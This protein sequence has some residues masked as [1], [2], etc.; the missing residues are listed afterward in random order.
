MIYPY[1]LCACRTPDRPG[2]LPRLSGYVRAA[3]T[4]WAPDDPDG[5][6]QGTCNVPVRP[7]CPAP[8]V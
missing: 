3:A 4:R 7:G 5:H 1:A 6:G 2:H 8:R